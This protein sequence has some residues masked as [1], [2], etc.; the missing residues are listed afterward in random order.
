M[1]ASDRNHKVAAFDE[2][3]D[4]Y[5]A[6]LQQG[7]RLSGEDSAYF[8]A[9]RTAWLG[10]RLDEMG[11]TPGTILD[12]GC[13]TGSTVP[14]L[15]D[16][17]GCHR[18]IATD[19]SAGLLDVARRDHRDANATFVTLGEK[20]DAEADVAYCN[21][22]FHHIPPVERARAVAYVWKALRPGGV[23]AFWENSPWNPGTRLVMRRIPFDRDAI[24][25]SPPQAR[26]L[27]RDGG[28]GVVRTDFAFI[29]PNVLRSLRKVERY[30][31][32][33]PVGAQYLVLA[34]KG[35]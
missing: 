27:L 14:Y 24:M 33:L 4:D 17:P 1:S 13:G 25:L 22:V 32:R 3:A 29:F 12:F 9:A 11:V 6:A 23:F 26:R 10:R 21:G 30:L 7:L 19:E 18:V 5:G 28:F 31:V 35:P 15:L 34:R 20:L 8:A 2:F 16:L